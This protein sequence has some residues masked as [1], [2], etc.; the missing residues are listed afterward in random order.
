MGHAKPLMLIIGFIVSV[1]GLSVVDGAYFDK[2]A[3]RVGLGISIAGFLVILA[4]VA[5]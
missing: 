4:A 5:S 3:E 1:W 2:R